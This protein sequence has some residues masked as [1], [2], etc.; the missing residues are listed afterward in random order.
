MCMLSGT[1]D[2]LNEIIRDAAI[3]VLGLPFEVASS[4]AHIATGKVTGFFFRFDNIPESLTLRDIKYDGERF[5]A[6]WESVSTHAEC[7]ICSK[8][9]ERAHSGRLY[10]EMVQDVGIHGAGLWHRIWRKKYHCT[11]DHC[12]HKVFLEG[13]TGLIE[14]RRAR[15][16]AGFA[17]HILQAAAATNN[18]AAARQLKAQGSKISGDTVT[19]VVLRYGAEEIEKN[20]YEKAGDVVNAGIDDINLR[21]GDS[22]TSCMVI[23]D[24]DTRKLLGIAR[25][26]T[27]DTAKGVLSMFPNLEIVG[28]DRGTAMASSANALGKTSVA[29]RYHL[30]DNMHDAIKR[31]LHETLPKS[32]YIPVGDSWACLSI[33]S[34]SGEIVVA[35]IPASLSESDIK[36]RARMAHLDMKAETKYRETL[37]VLELTVQGKH[38]QEISDITGIPIEDVRKLR[39]GMRE[40]VSDVEKRIDG[41]IADPRGSVKRQKSVSPSAGHSSKTIVE[42]YRDTVVAMRKEGK[43]HLAIHEELCR[44]GFKGSHSTVD[45]YIIKLEREN[46]IDKE[47]A[48]ARNA[49]GNYFIPLPERPGRISVRV[50]SVNTVY[51]RVLAMIK[52]LRH[53][54]GGEGRGKENETSEHDPSKKKQFAYPSKQQDETPAGA[55]ICFELDSNRANRRENSGN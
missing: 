45:N 47:I 17:K 36:Q 29:D 1:L 50:Y 2:S 42:P 43:S 3:E 48:D 37:R 18:E 4:F 21:K 52:A 28:R 23:V 30:T 11:N 46:S 15:M 16:T 34:E 40:T 44:L 33:D 27:A 6:E 25:G 54:G 26:T 39:S 12:I 5:I 19:R 31:T 41:Y 7:P 10:C 49:A 53:E 13:F 22:G 35:D 24:L 14:M 9:S 20:F 38:A 8:I 51:N 32:M 55:D